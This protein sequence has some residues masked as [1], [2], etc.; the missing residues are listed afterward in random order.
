MTLFLLVGGSVED[1]VWSEGHLLESS[2][3]ALLVCA[4]L[5]VD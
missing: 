3:I 4:L 5:F 1:G 2:G